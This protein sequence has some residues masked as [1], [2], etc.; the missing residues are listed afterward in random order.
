VTERAEEV[1]AGGAENYG[2]VVR[3]GDTVRRPLR[4]YSPAVHLLL[5]HL[6]SVGFDGAPRLLG[7]DDAGREVLGYIPGEVAMAPIPDWARS[8]RTADSVARLIRDYHA[9]VASFRWPPDTPWNSF[10]EPR[11]AG[12]QLLCHNDPVRSN[13]VCRDGLAVAL[14]DF[15]RAAPAL[16]EWE[17]A[18]AIQQWIPLRGEEDEGDPRNAGPRTAE[19]IRGFCDAYGLDA[20][21]RPR[22]LDAIRDSEAASR[23]MLEKRAA[24]GHPVYQRFLREGAAERIEA[25]RVWLDRHEE[26][27]R[28]ALR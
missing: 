10:V 15:D 4:P 23:T 17:T 28:E 9:A 6:E 3:V 27:I 11:W 25:R 5:R 14:I 19:R 12:G 22:V 21:R 24:E 13:I 16:P 1:L 7:L 18:L 26:L 8:R 2:A 20:V